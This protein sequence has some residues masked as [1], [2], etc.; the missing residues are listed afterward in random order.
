MSNN[1]FVADCRL[2]L[3]KSCFLALIQELLGLGDKGIESQPRLKNFSP[4]LIWPDL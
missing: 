3:N 1:N 2:I 4:N